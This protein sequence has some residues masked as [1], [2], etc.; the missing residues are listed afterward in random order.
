MGVRA[1]YRRDPLVTCLLVGYLV[2]TAVVVALTTGNVGTLVRHRTLIVPFLV[3]L[4]ALGWFDLASR[5]FAPNG[6]A[7]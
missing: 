2:P 6:T 4:S 1:G 7:R 5:R 3:W